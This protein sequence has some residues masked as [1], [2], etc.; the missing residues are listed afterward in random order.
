MPLMARTHLAFIDRKCKGTL[1]LSPSLQGILNS[2]MLPPPSILLLFWVSQN[3][4]QM[5]WN[6]K[7]HS[8][9]FRELRTE[10]W[11]GVKLLF[12]G[13]VSITVCWYLIKPL[14]GEK[15]P[16]CI[17]KHLAQEHTT[18]TMIGVKCDLVTVL[19]RTNN[20]GQQVSHYPDNKR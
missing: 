3:L 1:L 7:P 2:G 17:L 9:K 13:T 10:L 20:V 18:V 19:Q 5:S 12:S 14:G 6:S 16:K 4:T 11:G 15:H 8:L